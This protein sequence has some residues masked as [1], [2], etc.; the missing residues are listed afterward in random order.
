MNLD[1]PFEELTFTES[2]ELFRNQ[3]MEQ[4]FVKFLTKLEEYSKG[5]YDKSI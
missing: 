4:N 3:K 5:K 1:K 2:I